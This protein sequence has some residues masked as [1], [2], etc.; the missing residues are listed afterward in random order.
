MNPSRTVAVAG[1]AFTVTAPG[2]L[3][4]Q[5]AMQRAAAGY[6]GSDVRVLL[7]EVLLTA[8]RHP[9]GLPLSRSRL[10]ALPVAGGDALLTVLLELVEQQRAALVLSVREFPGWVEIEGQE[11][12]LRLQ[13]WTF[14]ARNDALRRALRPSGD[15]ITV[16]LAAFELAMVLH[17]VTTLDGRRLQLDH[18]AAWPV[19]LGETVM[20]ALERLCSAGA[21]EE[22]LLQQCVRA[23]IDHPDL[24]LIRLCRAFGWNPADVERMDARLAERLLVAIKAMETPRAPAAPPPVFDGEGVTRIIV[25]DD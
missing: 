19:P 11:V 2:W 9:D 24:A 12:G 14:G 18:L 5:D 16:D 3:A 1:D 8:V 21:E 6:A 15:G 25:M 13:P 22:A 23:G 7:D 4:W 20:A 10:E 17:C